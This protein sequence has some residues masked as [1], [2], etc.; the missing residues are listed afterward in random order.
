MSWGDWGFIDTPEVQHRLAMAWDEWAD[1]VQHDPPGNGTV[2]NRCWYL[3]DHDGIVPKVMSP[4]F[5]DLTYFHH[6][7]KK[8]VDVDLLQVD[9]D[10]QKDGVGEALIRRLHGDY[11]DHKINPGSLSPDG[12]AFYLRM[13]EKE[14][15]ARDLVTAAN[16]IIEAMAWDEWRDKVKHSQPSDDW[17]P[18]Q[19][20]PEGAYT[21]E[22]LNSEGNVHDISDLTY[23]LR[24]D[25][26]LHVDML[27]VSPQY[28]RQG[29]AEAFMRRMNEDYPDH[30]ID[31][32]SMTQQGRGFYDRMLQ[33]EP[34]AKDLVTAAVRLLHALEKSEL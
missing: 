24:G 2:K 25:N 31:P 14:P 28:Q 22:H 3:V 21:V 9:P 30:V 27:Y 7:D 15:A 6:P 33:K 10:F 8:R 32:G 20:Y 19:R 17:R 4:R 11:P 26:E 18:H 34:R 12:Q 5:S 16:R 23:S 1:K 13:L 29:L